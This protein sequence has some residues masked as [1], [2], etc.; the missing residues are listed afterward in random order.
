M[1]A[2]IRG[3]ALRT[4]LGT[5]VDEVV[6]RL[7]IGERAARYNQRFFSATYACRLAASIPAEPAASPHARVLSRIGLFGVEAG[8][9]ALDHAGATGGPRLGLF[10]AMGGLRAHW[11]DIMPAL[12][13]QRADQRAPYKHGFKNLH[14]FWMLKHL[15]NNA[16]ALLAERIGARGEGA[17]FAGAN[18]GAQALVDAIHTL[19]AGTIDT[20]LVVAY[21]SLLEPE[22]LV[23]MA[24]SGALATCELDTLSAPYDR[25][26]NGVVPGEAAAAVVITR[27]DARTTVLAYIEAAEGADGAKGNPAAMTLGRVAAQ[28]AQGDL[29]IDGCGF[30]QQGFDTEERSE[31][32]RAVSPSALLTATQAATGYLGAAT[33]LV[34]AIEMAQLLRLR[35]LPPVAGLRQA[36]DGK[37]RLVTQAQGT[38]ATSALAVSGG[39]PGLVGAARVCVPWVKRASQS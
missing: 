26:A 28:L 17:T 35:R 30:A 33:L 25:A 9:E 11:D 2:A 10:S 15:S 27:A 32:A 8:L 12:A 18:A 34:Q 20:A 36:A 16:H 7:L 29:V 19:E 14:P 23:E 24:S 3:W 13:N 39:A 4:P 6:E 38:A 31:L 21:D 37:L 5:S 1:R 22:T